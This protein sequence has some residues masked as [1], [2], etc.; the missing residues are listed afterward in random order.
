MPTGPALSPAGRNLRAKRAIL[1]RHR[2]PD[3]PE[4]IQ[5]ERDYRAEVLAE[6]VR[7]VVD[8]FP[9]LTAAQRDRIAALLCAPTSSGDRKLTRSHAKAV[10]TRCRPS[11]LDAT[12]AGSTA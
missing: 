4:T 6:H 5:A 11:E 10:A 9:P 2:G 3:A 1:T 8:S 12:D 7:K